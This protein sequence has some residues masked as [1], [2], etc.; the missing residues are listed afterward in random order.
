M[1]LAR[2]SGRYPPESVA[3]SVDRSAPV[4]RSVTAGLAV[5]M[6]GGLAGLTTVSS[7]VPRWSLAVP[8]LAS[9]L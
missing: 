1:L 6:S 8:L 2:P 7:A 3:E 4:V 5:V 9:P